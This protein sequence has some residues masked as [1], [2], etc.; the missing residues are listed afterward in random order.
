VSEYSSFESLICQHL[1][2]EQTSRLKQLGRVASSQSQQLYLVGGP[3]RDLLDG[4]TPEDIDLM[5]VGNAPA[6]AEYLFSN[7]TELFP[8]SDA[9]IDFQSFD[10]FL[11]AKLVFPSAVFGGSKTLD[12]A[13]ARRESYPHS[14]AQPIVSASTL[15][16]D[17]RRRDFSVNAMAIDVGPECFGKLED[18][19]A[20][21][22]ALGAR[23]L[24]VLHDDSFVDD[25]ARLLRAVRFSQRFNFKLAP[26]TAELFRI[27]IDSAFLTRLPPF[28]FFDEMK[29]SFSE[30][31]PYAVL[32]EF[33]RLGVLSQFDE[34][35]RGAP[36]LESLNS[37]LVKIEMGR[38]SLAS[39]AEGEGEIAE[40]WH[41]VL[42]LLFAGLSESEFRRHLKHYR[43]NS[44]HKRV[45]L[46]LWVELNDSLP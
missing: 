22:Q 38:E 11:T 27:G 13:T 32:L 25:P 46:R 39:T 8:Q 14:G 2:A 26:R 31:N 12:F 21:E 4:N 3:V 40:Q 17:L 9:P 15:L 37:M 10:K 29:K 45:L 43:V 44:K 7:W 20:G 35:L 5:I 18:P 6:F 33:E 1:G 16:V 19:M 28:R 41:G 23:E 36:S 24:R 34:S 42:V 30:R